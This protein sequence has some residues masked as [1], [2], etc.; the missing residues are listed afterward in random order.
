M[1]ARK[2]H[3]EFQLRLLCIG[4]DIKFQVMCKPIFLSMKLNENVGK[5]IH[6]YQ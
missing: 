4:S 2:L 1:D 6:S 3:S 5:L